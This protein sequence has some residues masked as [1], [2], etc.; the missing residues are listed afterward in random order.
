MFPIKNFFRRNQTEDQTLR[1]IFDERKHIEIELQRCV[2]DIQK[3]LDDI[4]RRLMVA[5]E[6]GAT[7]KELAAITREEDR[8]W[9]MLRRLQASL[10]PTEDLER[11]Y[12]EWMA[13]AGKGG[14]R[15]GVRAEIVAS[16]LKVRGID[17]ESLQPASACEGSAQD[18]CRGDA[19]RRPEEEMRPES[20]VPS[21][22]SRAFV[23]W[24]QGS[25]DD[26]LD[27][28]ERAKSDLR[29]AELASNVNA[30]DAYEIVSG[31]RH[32][33]A[34]LRMMDRAE[35]RRRVRM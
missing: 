18:I 24:E 8:L 27:E 3:R 4:D 22:E 1:L 33:G 13:L 20:L 19:S 12:I 30:Q 31:L 35:G 9:L 28:I 16:E 17:V 5:R 10:R 23:V 7:N 34:A 15:A 11:Q 6:N 32:H 2:S 21:P 26:I 25:A 14:E 29:R